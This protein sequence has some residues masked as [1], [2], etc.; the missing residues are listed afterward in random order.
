MVFDH[1]VLIT[2]QPLLRLAAPDDALAVARVHV[3]SWQTGYRG[4]L[5]DRYLDQLRAE[6]RA[7]RYD[8]RSP[9]LRKPVTAVAVSGGAICGF[10]TTSPARDADA[11]GCGEL[12]ALYVDPDYWGQ[13][14]GTALL[15]AAHARLAEQGFKT[16]VLWVLEGNARAC[17]FYGQHGW[18]SDASRRVVD[19][20]GVM[21]SELRYSRNLP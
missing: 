12:C 6:D 15:T 17:R 19:C 1:A 7:R 13:G 2:E 16:A 21:A 3:R 14:V 10:V 20:W 18:I 11:N 4:L 9:E 5:P 8:F